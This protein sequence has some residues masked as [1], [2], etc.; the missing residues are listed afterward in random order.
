M[1]RLAVLVGIVAGCGRIGF[2]LEGRGSG[3]SDGGGGS[4]TDAHPADASPDAQIFPCA[5]FDVT[6]NGSPNT[7]PGPDGAAWLGDHYA[8]LVDGS[9]DVVQLIQVALD[10][11]ITYGQSFVP[12]T[13]AMAWSGN[14]LAVA[15]ATGVDAPMQLALFDGSGNPLGTSTLSSI[16]SNAYVVWAGDRFATTWSDG[17]VIRVVE[18]DPAGNMLGSAIF[19]G[20]ETTSIVATPNAYLISNPPDTMV[21]PRPLTSNAQSVPVGVGTFMTQLDNLLV[22]GS[23]VF[24]ADSRGV[25]MLDDAGNPTTSPQAIPK[26]G[27]DTIGFTYPTPFGSKIRIVGALSN[28]GSDESLQVDYDPIAGTFGTPMTAFMF[29]GESDG[30]TVAY[31]P[32]QLLIVQQFGSATR[33]V[34]QCP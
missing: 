18:T 27:S 14:V 32:N 23:G 24:L 9:N 13:S 16:S 5:P 29:S 20:Q 4:V 31:G 6:V 1:R 15:F 8:A 11:S 7:Y 33:L 12:D 19:P 26:A 25:Q 28:S 34:Q 22:Y 10:G 3:S 2:G 30:P 17:T 21:V